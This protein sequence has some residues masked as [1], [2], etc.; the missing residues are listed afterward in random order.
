MRPGEF[1]G[2][3]RR[4]SPDLRKIYKYLGLSLLFLQESESSQKQVQVIA[5]G[6]VY[7]SM[8]R[9]PLLGALNH[10]WRFIE[11]FR[12]YPPV[13]R[14]KIP[15]GVKLEVARFLC[16][17]PL[18]KLDFRLEVSPM[19]TA[20]DASTTGGGLTVSTGLTG[21]GQAASVSFSRGDLAEPDDLHGVLTIGLFD[22]IGALRVAAD[23]CGMAVIGHISVEI[24]KEA[25]RVLESKFPSTWFVNG[26]VDSVDEEEVRRWACHYSQA[27]LVPIGAGPP[28]QGVSGLN[29]DRRGA[30]RDH[31]S[32]LFVHVERIRSLVKHHFPWAQV[33]YLAESV[34][35][36]DEQ[37]RC[38]MSESFGDS[39]NNID[40]SGVSLA[41]RPRLYWCDWE[42]SGGD[43]VQVGAWQGHGAGAM[44]K[45]GAH[46]QGRREGLFGA[47]VQ[48]RVP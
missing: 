38:V 30:L 23:V 2:T 11:E 25:S 44:R 43:G 40:A 4:Q 31:R 47:R 7:L 10:I 9:R 37:D 26:G 20:S 14:L 35:S 17:I 28:C 34:A 21:F 32:S 13:V 19:V 6:L 45:V 42:L 39:A 12:G 5:G 29:V 1:R 24:H 46:C 18:A 41:R 22:G 16:L 48:E 33:R 8:F 27:S 3:P 15:D 36:M